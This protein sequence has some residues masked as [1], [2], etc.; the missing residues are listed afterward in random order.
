M[1]GSVVGDFIGSVYE[2]NNVKTKKFDLIKFYKNGKVANRFTD[3]SVMTVA[4]ADVVTQY[5]Q[6]D[7]KL[8]RNEIATTL[9]KYGREYPNAGYGGMFRKWLS[10]TSPEPYN[11][12]GN[13]ALMRI[14]PV[15]L[16]KRM[17]YPEKKYLAN[18]VTSVTHNHPSALNAVECYVAIVSRLSTDMKNKHKEDANELCR[19]MCDSYGYN[20]HTLDYIRPTYKFDVTC[21]GTLPV[22]VEAFIESKSYIDTVRSAI[23][24]GGDSDTIAAIA[25][26]IAEAYYGFDKIIDEIKSHCVYEY[27]KT[28]NDVLIEKAISFDKS[29]CSD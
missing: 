10:S 22:A 24:V 1:I 15:A 26:G 17:S 3:D 16:C 23:S 13:G 11:S 14:S 19:I 25:G 2:F 27:L 21:R 4:V 12:F 6:N 9:Q 29:L 8:T 7:G 5:L 20:L 28:V 18:V